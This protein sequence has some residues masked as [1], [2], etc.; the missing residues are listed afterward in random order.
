MNI[1]NFKRFPVLLPVILFFFAVHPLYPQLWRPFT[2]LNIIKTE[3]FDIIFPVESEHTARAL[4]QFADQVYVEMS[5]MLGISLPGRLPVTITPHTELF[6]GYYR[7]LPSSHIVLFD[8][9]MDIG[10]TSFNDNLRNLFIHELAHAISL[11]TR[12]PF[13]TFLHRIFGNWVSPAL[14]NAPPFMVEGVTIAFE[15]MEGFGRANDP[16]IRQYLR[17]AI[18]EDRFLSPLQASALYDVT[19]RES[20]YDYGGLFSHWLIENYGMEKYSELWQGIGGYAAFSFSV[21]RSGFY[22]IFSD[23]YGLSFVDQWHAF[24]DSLALSDLERN[25]NEVISTRRKFYSALRVNNGSLYFLN[26]TDNNISIYNTNSQ[27]MRRINISHSY[28]IDIA[29]DAST[30]LLSAYDFSGDRALA[31]VY[32]YNARNG[33]KTGRILNGIYN[34]RYF[35]D[36]VIGIASDLHNNS[37]V[38]DDFNGNREILLRG[39]SRLMFSSPEILDENRIVFIASNAGV[40]ELWLYDYSLNE[41]YLIDFLGTDYHNAFIRDL[42]VADGKIFF[43]HNSN[44]R[45]YKLGFLDIERREAIFNNRD[46][47]GGVFNPVFTNDS[48]YYIA[49]FTGEDRILEFPEQL[50]FLSGRRY[51][52]VLNRIFIEDY[53]L[54]ENIYNGIANNY[55]S[56]PYM[57]PFQFWLPLPLLRSFGG[58]LVQGA[59][60][61]SLISDPAE[62]NMIVIEAYGDLNYQMALINQLSWQNNSMGFPLTLSFSDRIIEG[63][64]IYRSTNIDLNTSYNRVRRG[65]QYNF[66]LGGGYTRN[67]AEGNNESAYLWDEGES[68]IYGNVSF[69]FSFSYLSFYLSGISYLNEFLPRFD[70][71]LDLDFNPRFPLTLSFFGAYD[72]RG[73]NLHGVSNSYSQTL[74]PSYALFEYK[75]PL[76]LNLDWIAGAELGIN[77]FTLEIQSNLS[78]IYFNRIGGNLSLRNQ[79]YDSQDHYGAEG[80]ELDNYRLI[81]SLMLRLGMEISFLPIIKIPLRAEPYVYGVWKFSNTINKSSSIFLLGLGLNITF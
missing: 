49:S 22:R 70:A 43:I 57:N 67:A 55:Y 46:F 9:P 72:E 63:N 44:D 13:N 27:S 8:T 23:V 11:N 47:S 59:G 6:N 24:R 80:M 37:I 26:L 74:I 25:P 68:F 53:E 39:N 31:L 56:F 81:Q 77:I 73:M 41:T 48:L 38:F 30:L 58:N 33:R 21:Y 54:R 10:W 62:R 1:I 60:I 65:R 32:E 79:I 69:G 61:L 4:A 34:A 64:N 45:M 51:E 71:A 52:V 15:S 17:Q 28:D 19:L 20:Y 66:S 3:Y 14:I 50:D 76:D 75:S 29:P 36:G 2:S 35:R 5:T 18:H 40:R 16:R 42:S 7:I 12:N 78:H